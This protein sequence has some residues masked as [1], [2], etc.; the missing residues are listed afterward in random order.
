MWFSQMNTFASVVAES[1]RGG[2][3]SL[4][5][6]PNYLENKM[7]LKFDCQIVLSGYVSYIAI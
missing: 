5:R 2:F 7:A 6:D 1:V 4:W 3:V